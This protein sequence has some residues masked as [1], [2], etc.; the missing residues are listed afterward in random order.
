MKSRRSIPTPSFCSKLETFFET[1]DDDAREVSKILGIA[2]TSRAAGG[3]GQR[4][5][6]AGIPVTSLEQYLPALVKTGRKIVIV[7]QLEP[8]QKNKLVKRGVTR[9]ITPG[10][11][12][13]A[14][15]VEEQSNNY[16]M[17]IY[18][19]MKSKTR[20]A[21]T[22]TIAIATVDVSTGEFYASYFESEVD[23]LRRVETEQV[24]YQPSEIILP[25]FNSTNTNEQELHQLYQQVKN[26]CKEVDPELAIFEIDD[27]YFHLP[28]CDQRIKDHFKVHAPEGLGLHAEPLRQAVG[29]VLGYLT[30]MNPTLLESITHVQVRSFKHAMELDAAT[31]RN[32]ELLKNVY[33][34]SQ[35]GSLYKVLN[36][37]KTAMGARLLK[38]WILNPLTDPKR[39][40]KRLE[41]VAALHQDSI[42]IA[43]LQ[44]QLSECTDLE[45]LIT[46]VRYGSANARDLLSLKDSLN[47]IPQLMKLV[48]PLQCELFKELM[49][50]MDEDRTFI[51]NLIEQS[52]NPDAPATLRD[53]NLIKDGYNSQVD[54]FRR[55]I[56]GGERWIKEFEERE[57]Q[58]T[59]LKTL[60]VGFNKVHGYYI[61]VTKKSLQERGV[62]SGYRRRQ[63]LVNAERFITDELH[64]LEAKM[65]MANE[66]IKELEYELFTSIRQQ[67]A[68]KMEAVKKI[69]K[70]VATLDVIA[71]FALVARE[72]DYTKP[73]ITTTDVIQIEQGR[74]PVVEQLQ[75]TTG[76]IPNDTYLDC[77]ESMIHII[78]GPNMAGKSTYIR[79]VAL[80]VLMAQIGSFVPAKHAR[81]GVVN[82][83][84]TRIGALDRLA[85]GQSTFMVEMIETANILNSA[86]KKSLIVLD[87]IGR[88]T[89]TYDGL[90]L[91]FAIAEYIHDYIQAKTLF[92]TH[93]HQLADLETYLPKVKN[94]NVLVHEGK[95]EIQFLYRIAPGATD[96]S[97]GIHVARIAGVP[98]PVIERA[99]VILKNLESQALKIEKKIQATR[100]QL[101]LTEILSGK[102]YFDRTGTSKK[103]LTSASRNFQPPPRKLSDVLPAKLRGALKEL[104]D[105]NVNEMTPL[106][107]LLI[108]NQMQE[109]LSEFKSLVSDDSSEEHD[110]NSS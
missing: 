44:E 61:E 3:N 37:T 31:Q 40:N 21:M 64:E 75:Q 84:F 36:R 55:I 83:I 94:F 107:A 15:V 88:G 95:D 50:I 66:R 24:R 81:I 19:T 39:I 43:E 91:A 53:G 74:H 48:K 65:T 57:R 27:S 8:P 73:E 20:N 72:W 58:R 99:Q 105:V 76:F 71:S 59:G 38:K 33:D 104:L 13:E 26:H 70:F 30:D 97:F 98:Q 17:G 60:K 14:G 108:L 16:L 6:L 35:E 78:T 32:L 79:Q 11:V 49:D 52:I 46:R 41:A 45:R 92:A 47:R 42:L 68:D 110:S 34:G 23:W 10:T 12:F 102:Q 103:A 18:L 5:P 85:V 2:L 54:E 62:P 93:Y 100:R 7:E 109:R 77:Q 89:A 69:A 101:T 22:P 4:R 63:T 82:R 87:E 29:A 67:V 80:I 106:Q 28:S 86:T 9:I 25:R 51:V 1:F 96:K 56:Q 90:S